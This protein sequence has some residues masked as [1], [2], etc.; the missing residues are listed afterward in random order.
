MLSAISAHGTRLVH[1]DVRDL[2]LL[3]RGED[4]AERGAEVGGGE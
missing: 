4:H 3:V 2:A 1:P